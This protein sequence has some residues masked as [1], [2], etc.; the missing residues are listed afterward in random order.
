VTGLEQRLQDGT[1]LRGAAQ[2]G[3]AQPGI[4]VRARLVQCY[5]AVAS[6]IGSSAIA[7][8]LLIGWPIAAMS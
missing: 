6:G 1:A 5:G 8:W 3:R 7:R 4:P 2:P